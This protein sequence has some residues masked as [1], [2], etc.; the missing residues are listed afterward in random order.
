MMLPV[1]ARNK[2]SYFS[3]L[4]VERGGGCLKGKSVS[5]V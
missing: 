4:R 3:T 2:H 5:S 1:A